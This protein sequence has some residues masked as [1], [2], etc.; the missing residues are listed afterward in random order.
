MEL[1]NNNIKTRVKE[2]IR[3]IENRSDK[4]KYIKEL[5]IVLFEIRSNK[6]ML[7]KYSGLYEDANDVIIL[8]T[9]SGPKTCAYKS[10]IKKSKKY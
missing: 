5:K 3:K 6:K 7:E 4:D 9:S 1:G 8:Y 2:L 10:H